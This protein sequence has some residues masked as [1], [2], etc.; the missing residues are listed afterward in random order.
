LLDAA[1]SALRE[2]REFYREV[3]PLVTEALTAFDPARMPEEE[4]VRG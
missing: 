4:R 2:Q 1:A 3:M